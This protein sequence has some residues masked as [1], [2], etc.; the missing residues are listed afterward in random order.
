MIRVEVLPLLS[1]SIDCADA[2]SLSRARHEIIEQL[3]STT[4][5]ATSIAD[6]EIVLGEMLAAQTERGH[7]A[8]AIT[9][10][11][12]GRS[13]AIHIY[14]QGQP[15]ANV[16]ENPL[17]EAILQRMRVPMSVERSEQGA[18]ITL[19]LLLGHERPLRKRSAQLSATSL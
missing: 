18:H 7:L 11:R 14:A 12:R 19:R 1:W 13:P 16:P 6:I 15:L 8:L 2:S 3:R 10:E 5:D 17:R 4:S 9:L